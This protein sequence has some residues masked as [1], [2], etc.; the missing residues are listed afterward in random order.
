MNI[1]IKNQKTFKIKSD[2]EHNITINVCVN[3]DGSISMTFEDIL[4]VN[5]EKNTV[6][7]TKENK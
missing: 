7:F 1:I 3:E 4:N 5:I 6:T 2:G